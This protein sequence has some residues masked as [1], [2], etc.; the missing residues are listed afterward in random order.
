MVEGDI[1]SKHYDFMMGNL[2]INPFK[3]AQVVRS[4]QG[5]AENDTYFLNIGPNVDV[6]FI[7]ICTYAIDELFNDRQN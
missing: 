1:I 6:A 2:N 3:I 7:C 5:W 4:F